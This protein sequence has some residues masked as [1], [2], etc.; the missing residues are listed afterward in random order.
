MLFRSYRQLVLFP[1]QAM[2]NLYDMYY[3]QAM[4]H[5][6]TRTGSPEANKWAEQVQKCFRRDS[7][8]C[9]AY[10]HEIAGG[11]WNGM[12]IQKHIGYRSWNDNFPHEMLPATT[13][14]PDATADGGFTFLHSPGYVSMEAAHFFRAEASQ[15]TAWSIYPDYGRTLSAVALV[16]YTQ[17]VGDAA[18]TY[19][20]TLPEDIQ[21]VKVH[22]VV[23]STLDFLN[24]GGHQCRVSL[25]GGQ[26][27]TVNFNK[28]LLDQQP[29]MYSEYYPTVARRVIEK[30]VELPVDNHGTHEL[31][32]RPQHPGIVF[33][34]VVVD[35]GGYKPS[36]LFMD[37]SP[38]Q[39][40]E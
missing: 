4:N 40:V 33:E 3:A 34:K 26:P 31:T 35:F 30:I 6:L 39:H 38:Y 11:K 13:T 15:G 27:Q 10:N 37:E 7:L 23:K 18:L 36:Y 32:L 22:L 20:F 28:T 12:M 25:D 19:R 21:Q 5:H 14:V 2:A 1:V 17:P 24:V 29:Y 16:P 9:A 8:L